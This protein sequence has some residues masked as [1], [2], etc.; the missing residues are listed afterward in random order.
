MENALV[1]PTK[2]RPREFCVDLALTAALRVFWTKGFDG[3]SMTDLT[4]AMGITRPSLYAA[5]GNKEAL[6]RKALDLYEREKLAYVGQA[7]EAPTAR[8]VAERLLEGALAIQTN[9]CDPKGCLGVMASIGCSEHAASIKEEVI[10]RRASTE[11]ALVARFEQAQLAGD[12]P[13]NIEPKGLA[14]LLFAVLQ[15]LTVQAGAGASAS[16]LRR[17]IDTSLQLWPGR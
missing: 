3:A 8:G 5:F 14:H 13:A 7:L 15:G 9:S 2:G 12:L 10:A 17:L 4:E 16:D 11:R 6:F 1:L